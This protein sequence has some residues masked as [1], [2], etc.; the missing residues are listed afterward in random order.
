M[1]HPLWL[2]VNADLRPSDQGHS[3]ECNGVGQ[4]KHGRGMQ[5]HGSQSEIHHR[6][7][8]DAAPVNIVVGQA[9][10]LGIPVV[11]DV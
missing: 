8:V 5:P 11:P 9:D 2:E 10:A 6:N 1:K 4:M 7:A 3:P